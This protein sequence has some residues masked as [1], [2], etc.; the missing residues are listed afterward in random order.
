MKPAEAGHDMLKKHEK[1]ARD[2]SQLAKSATGSREVEMRDLATY[3]ERLYTTTNPQGYVEVH[4]K[5]SL[6]SDL[7][8]KQLRAEALLKGHP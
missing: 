8:V 7:D 5:G 2:L 6:A 1:T 4:N 3:F